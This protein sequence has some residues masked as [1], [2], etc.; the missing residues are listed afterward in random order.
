MS[1]DITQISVI[2]DRS[3]SMSLMVEQVVTGF[4]EFLAAQRK[5]PGKTRWTLMQ[6]DKTGSG[7]GDGAL[8]LDY[9][10]MDRKGREVPKLADKNFQPRGM[11]PLLDAVGTEVSRLLAA[12]DGSKTVVFIITDGMENA[13]TE[14]TQDKVKKLIKRAEKKGWQIIFMAANLDAAKEAAFIGASAAHTI[15]TDAANYATSNWAATNTVST[16]RATG[17]AVTENQD[18]TANKSEVTT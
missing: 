12:D 11:T 18:D 9:L 7:F 1:D 16:Y 10:F 2:L 14:Y 15:S 4:N 8:A 17:K 6:F 3:G 13:S 5:V